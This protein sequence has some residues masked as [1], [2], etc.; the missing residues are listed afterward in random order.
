MSQ[1]SN[2]EEKFFDWINGWDAEDFGELIVCNTGLTR[3][4]LIEFAL[5]N[6]KIDAIRKDFIRENLY[7]CEECKEY[8]DQIGDI[9]LSNICQDCL[10]TIAAR[11]RRAETVEPYD[12]RATE[13]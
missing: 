6:S 8:F 10:E 12:L 3:R 2:L 11:K 9:G 13:G 5:T 4:E 1:V 7:Q